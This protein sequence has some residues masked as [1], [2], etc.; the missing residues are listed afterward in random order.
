MFITYSKWFE[1][2][3]ISSNKSSWLRG[4]INGVINSVAEISYKITKETR[5]AVN[6][7]INQRNEIM[8]SHRFV[9]IVG[10]HLTMRMSE[11]IFLFK[12]KS[13]FVK[14]LFVT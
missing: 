5:K 12:H 10:A 9:V 11:V 3:S 1:S 6:K 2:R 7:S 4:L 14:G 8:Q 13:V